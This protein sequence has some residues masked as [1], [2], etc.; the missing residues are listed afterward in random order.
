MEDYLVTTRTY[1]MMRNVTTECVR[2]WIKN[3]KVKN[4][5][6]DGVNFVVLTEEE[7]KQRKEAGV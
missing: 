2:K 7:V 6:I 1:A 5:I 3:G 4:K